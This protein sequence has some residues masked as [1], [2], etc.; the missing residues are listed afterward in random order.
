MNCFTISHKN[1]ETNVNFYGKVEFLMYT[2]R[3]N[4]KSLNAEK[5][6]RNKSQTED[7][8][9]DFH[10]HIDSHSLDLRYPN[11]MTQHNN[12]EKFVNI[13]CSSVKV[14]A[15]ESLCDSAQELTFGKTEVVDTGVAADGRWHR[16]GYS[17]I[18]GVVT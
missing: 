3:V 1:N 18:N 11:A 5:Q 16:R 10:P 12:C 4:F 13:V 14:V 6:L 9:L 17:S 7:W 2:E 15:Q 8:A